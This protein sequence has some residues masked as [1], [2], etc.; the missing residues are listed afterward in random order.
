[1]KSS[2]TDKAGHALG[3][4]LLWGGKNIQTVLEAGWCCTVE[5]FLK[6]VTLRVYRMVADGERA[7]SV[8]GN[9]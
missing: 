6:K 4:L 5:S 3:E 9:G 8:L 1:M 2:E 7:Q